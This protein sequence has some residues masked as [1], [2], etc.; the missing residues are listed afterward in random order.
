MFANAHVAHIVDAKRRK[1][2]TNRLTLWVEQ[3][4]QWHNVN[5]GEEFHAANLRRLQIPD[6]PHRE[7]A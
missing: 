1:A 3:A 4:F 2:V 7:F 6:T 5:I